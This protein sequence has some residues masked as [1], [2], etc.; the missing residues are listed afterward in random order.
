MTRRDQDHIGWEDVYDLQF[1]PCRKCGRC[2]KAPCN[3][4][5]GYHTEGP[6][7]YSCQ[8]IFYPERDR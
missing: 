1:E 3:D 6:W 8:Y 5:E 4:A 2:V 7:D